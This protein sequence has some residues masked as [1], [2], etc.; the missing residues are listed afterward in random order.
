MGI[1]GNLGR[2]LESPGYGI[3]MGKE[4][5]FH[6]IPFWIPGKKRLW[7]IGQ[8]MALRYRPLPWGHILQEQCARKTV[9]LNLCMTLR[10]CT[11]HPLRMKEEGSSELGNLCLSLVLARNKMSHSPEKNCPFDLISLF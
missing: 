7:L 1:C 9:E 8:I 4:D 2:A 10:G 11:M 3:G 6:P 5:Q